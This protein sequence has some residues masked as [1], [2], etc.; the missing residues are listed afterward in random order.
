MTEGDSEDEMA[1]RNTIEY[2]AAA[3][4]QHNVPGVLANHAHDIEVLDITPPLK[5]LGIDNYEKK[6]DLFF[7]FHEPSQAFDVEELAI[8]A[9][10]DVAFAIANVRYGL[11][12]SNDRAKEGRFLFKLTIGLRKVDGH[13]VVTHEHRCALSDG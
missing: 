13:W 7:K 6:W 4:R 10:K 8:S 11:G 9:G 1:I 12:R 5:S 3:V 2:W